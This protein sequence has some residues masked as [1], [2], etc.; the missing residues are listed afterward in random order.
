MK[1]GYKHTVFACCSG[2]IVQAIINNFPPL[3]Y[4][5]FAARLGIS[6]TKISLLITLN[7]VIQI[8]MDSLGTVM[9]DRIGDR[10]SAVFA[11]VSA[12]TGLI[13]LGVLPAVM[14]NK[15][16]AL[17]ISTVISAIGSGLVEVVTSPMF[18]AIPKDEV[19]FSMNFL[20]SFYCWGHA[21]VIL[22]SSAFF[23]LFNIERWFVLAFLWAVIPIIGG[24]LF[25]FV[26]VRMLGD[27]RTGSTLRY[28]V[29]KKE[30]WLFMI[31][32]LAAGASELGMAQWASYFAEEGLGISKTLGD[33][34]GPLAFAVAMGTT[35]LLFGIFGTNLKIDRWVAASFA[36]AVF[37][38]LLT[39]LAPLPALSL[40][41][42]AI[43]GVA[44]A[45]LWPGT[46][47]NAAEVLPRGGTPMFALFALAGDIG[48]AAGSSLIGLI[49]DGIV[50][51]RITP[52]LNFISGSPKAIGIKTGILLAAVFPLT[53]FIVSLVLVRCKRQKSE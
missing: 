48:C 25:I 50:L 5:M 44:V 40:I 11:N 20:H 51:G 34:L 12:A 24:I 33:L 19:K 1:L 52:F 31:I 15:F 10:W 30:F 23:A 46:Y 7:F 22:I 2:Y 49:S 47:T 37:S 41:G 45:L 28:L 21:G 39:A 38:Y 43:S 14:H 8:G 42:F 36:L 6:L 32:M 3:L 13:L 17:I 18:E 29:A 35:R 27:G 16:A 4:A 9:V 53:A 26:P